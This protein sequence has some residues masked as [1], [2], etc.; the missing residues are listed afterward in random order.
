[1]IGN[2]VIRQKC[3]F[4]F[5]VCSPVLF[6]KRNEA[7]RPTHRRG[8]H[9]AITTIPTAPK[10]RSVPPASALRAIGLHRGHNQLARAW[11][12][13]P[14]VAHL[15]HFSPKP[16]P[17]SLDVSRRHHVVLLGD[18]F[19]ELNEAEHVTLCHPRPIERFVSC[20]GSTSR[21]HAVYAALIVDADRN[22]CASS[23]EP[24]LKHPP[25]EP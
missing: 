21:I 22:H 7:P 16:F 18:L 9:I 11:S 20:A 23:T 24:G 5:S 3:G 2:K 19:D 10:G 8:R 4:A 17:H 14:G 15:E 13:L 12:R 6:V 1:M 25:R